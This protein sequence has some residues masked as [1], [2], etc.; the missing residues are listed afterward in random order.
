MNLQYSFRLK[1]T[2]RLPAD[3]GHIPMSSVIDFAEMIEQARL[4]GVLDPNSI[5]VVDVA[6]GEMLDHALTED[7]AYSDRGRIEWVIKDPSRTEYEIRFR[8]A[9]ERPPLQPREYVPLIGSGDLL[10][11][12]AGEPRPITLFQSMQLVDMTGDGRQDLVGGWNY[13]HRPGSPVSGIVCY[14]RVGEESEFIF[15]DL[16]RVRYVEEPGSRDFKHFS[17]VYAEADFADFTGNGLVDIVFAEVRSPAELGAQENASEVLFFLNTGERDHSGLPIFWRAASIYAPVGKISGLRAVDLD[18]DGVLDLVLNGQYI[19]NTNPEGWPF[20]PAEPVD[21]GIGPEPAFLDLDGDGRLDVLCLGGEGCD[22]SL[23]WRKNLG[24]QPPSFGPEE[25]LEGIEV[26][27]CTLVSAVAD[28]RQCGL[29]VQHN[30]FQNI[31]FFELVGCPGGQPR[32][33]HRG[34]AESLS[35]VMSLSDQAWPC[36]CDWNDDGVPDLLIGGGYGWPRIVVNQGREGRP[37]FSEPR[38]LLSE[39][40]PIRLLRD[41]I[42]SSHHWHNMGYPYPV[43]V[44]W[45][46]DGLKDLMLPNETNRIIWYKNIGTDSEPRFGPRRFLRVEGFPDSPEQRAASGRRAEDQEIPNA[47]YPKDDSSPFFWRTGAAF[48]DWNSDGLM[49][50]I[51]HDNHR[52]ATL[53][54]QYRDATGELRLKKQGPVRLEDG[55]LI[56]D[57]IVG[58]PMHWTESFRAVDWDGDGL[59]DL[60]Y[61]VAGTGKMYLLRNVGSATEPVFANPREFRCFGE[62]LGFTIHGPNP[63]AGDLNGDGKPDLLACV[64]W[65]VYPFFSHAALEMEEPPQY[66]IGPVAGSSRPAESP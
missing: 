17:G 63:W 64:E 56:D 36:I 42:L 6:T 38:P 15:G 49:D 52:K 35:A 8:T 44:D 20:E 29:L 41:E 24:G 23:Q 31:S 58:R 13:Y 4:P 14:P 9:A 66:R 34:R 16:V 32:F 51:T 28:R 54:V 26:D 18:Q 62:E 53:F 65:S 2:S 48:A 22:Q 40:E 43:L 7:F 27:T 46:G 12:N 3:L 19:R 57:A 33:E 5:E 45:D 10:R 60:I 11:Y 37:V 59:L 1:V 30:V 47:P 39:G 25:P 55:R 21:L 61:N 50:L